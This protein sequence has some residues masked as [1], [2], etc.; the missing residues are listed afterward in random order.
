MKCISLTF[1]FD[2]S[3]FWRE[4]RGVG[5]KKQHLSEDGR[6]DWR[7]EDNTFMGQF[8]LSEDL[9]SELMTTKLK[10]N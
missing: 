2:D 8:E 9:T 10:H 6:L 4:Q 3:F 7:F 5:V 1:L